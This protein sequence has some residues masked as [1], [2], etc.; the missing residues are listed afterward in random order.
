MYATETLQ[1]KLSIPF[2]CFSKVTLFF[3]T[4]YLQILVLGFRKNVLRLKCFRQRNPW[5]FFTFSRR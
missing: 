3:I 2:A 4:L 5:L 1:C